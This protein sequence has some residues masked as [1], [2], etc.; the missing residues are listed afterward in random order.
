MGLCSTSLTLAWVRRRFRCC[1]RLP[2]LFQHYNQVIGNWV[3]QQDNDPKH[4]RK[5]TYQKNKSSGV[6]ESEPELVMKFRGWLLFHISLV[7]DPYKKRRNQ[8]GLNHFSQ[9]CAAI[10]LFYYYNSYGSILHLYSIYLILHLFI[11]FVYNVT[12]NCTVSYLPHWFCGVCEVAAASVS[13]S[14]WHQW[15]TVPRVSPCS[16]RQTTEKHS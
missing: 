14:L 3:L 5:S 6:A 8:E 16:I 2:A 15:S 7:W 11:L 13:V 4:Y 10:D 12:F 9:H 1:W